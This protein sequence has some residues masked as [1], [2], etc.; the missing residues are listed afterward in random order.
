[1]SSETTAKAIIGE[2]KLEQE[3]LKVNKKG[4][5]LMLSASLVDELTVVLTERRVS[6]D[7][8]VEQIKEISDILS[9]QNL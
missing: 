5:K 9:E 2:T 6:R 7:A 1:M 4:E 3:K 8:L